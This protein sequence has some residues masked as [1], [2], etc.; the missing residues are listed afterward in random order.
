MTAYVIAQVKVHEPEQYKRYQAATSPTLAAYGGEF[1]V[2][3]GGEIK[4]F[5]GTWD[6]ERIAV[7]RFP[8]REQAEAWY[9][10]PEYQEALRIR[11]D[12]STTVLTVVDG[13]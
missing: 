5:G 6:V 13:A 9:H 12:A 1:L 7:I 3:G 11:G 2:R 4:H 10:S 8:S